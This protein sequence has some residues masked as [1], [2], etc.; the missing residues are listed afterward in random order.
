MRTG[1]M[2]KLTGVV[3]VFPVLGILAAW[4]VAP[5]DPPTASHQMFRDAAQELAL[6]DDDKSAKKR[7]F[8]GVNKC[9]P[10]CHDTPEKGDQYNKWKAT[11]HAKAYL[12]LATDKAKEI[13][14]KLGVEDPQKSEACLKCHVTALGEKKELLHKQFRIE[15][16]VQCE[17]C[18]GAGGD[19]YLKEVME[20]HDESI[21]NGLLM[22]DEKTC[23]QCH[24]KD[25]PTWDPNKPFRF[26]EAFHKIDHRYPEKIKCK[27]SAGAKCGCEKEKC[28][29]DDKTCPCHDP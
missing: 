5:H 26:K 17:S 24:N 20:K 28:S 3:I 23:A 27:C 14:K 18:H 1:R 19:Y 7:K 22:P 12:T 8:M 29:C 4:A 16:G 15:D 9:G 11:P 2:G 13:G 25:A 10:K 6:G 21:K